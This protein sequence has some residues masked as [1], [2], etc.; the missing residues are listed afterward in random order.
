MQTLT[1]QTHFYLGKKQDTARLYLRKTF[2]NIFCTLTD[3]RHRPIIC[4]TSGNSGIIGSKRRKRVPYALESIVKELNP[5]FKLYSIK[6]LFLII[7]MRINKYYHA[8]TRE[9]V[10]YGIGIKRVKVRRALAFNG[11]RGRKLR[12]R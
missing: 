4:K 12:R 10:F 2:S 6:S 8:L 1:K 3:I 9:L 5:Y 11:V 7:K